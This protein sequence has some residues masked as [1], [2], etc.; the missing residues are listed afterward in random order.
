MRFSSAAMKPRGKRTGRASRA[1]AKSR[2]RSVADDFR[3]RAVLAAD[4]TESRAESPVPAPAPAVAATLVL[5]ATCCRRRCRGTSR[6]ARYAARSAYEKASAA[7][8][9]L[10]R[11]REVSRYRLKRSRAWRLR[12][13]RFLPR[14]W[15]GERRED[16]AE[17]IDEKRKGPAVRRRYRQQESE[18]VLLERP[19]RVARIT[20]R[21]GFEVRGRANH[22]NDVTANC[23]RHCF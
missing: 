16:D 6:C 8:T 5:E 17:D 4:V 7:A 14:E 12:D 15:P 3:G 1:W 23:D 18:R 10:R 2:I 21:R 22:V 19:R 9:G 20:E 11:T 13:E